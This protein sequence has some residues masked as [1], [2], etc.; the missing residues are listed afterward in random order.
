MTALY[1]LTVWRRK[2]KHR[3]VIF[4]RQGF[5]VACAQNAQGKFDRIGT[6]KANLEEPKA[7]NRKRIVKQPPGN[8]LVDPNWTQTNCVE[9][10]QE[11]KVGETEQNKQKDRFKLCTEE[12][13]ME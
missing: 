3:C 5:L 2:L 13:K 1:N 4:R 12:N 8:G 6:A 11:D 9:A 7:I 10:S